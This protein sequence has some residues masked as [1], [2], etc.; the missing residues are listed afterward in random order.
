MSGK[1]QKVM[2]SQNTEIREMVEW[3]K[4]GTGGYS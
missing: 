4:S 3:E 1:S 2:K